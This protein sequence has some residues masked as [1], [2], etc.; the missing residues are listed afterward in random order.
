MDVHMP[1]L[2]GISATQLILKKR[3]T[4]DVTDETRVKVR[5]FRSDETV[6]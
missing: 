3:P 5:S 6:A 1:V 2:D 4:A